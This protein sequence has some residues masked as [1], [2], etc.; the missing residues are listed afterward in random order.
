MT[1][2]TTWTMT[3]AELARAWADHYGY[4]GNRGGWIGYNDERLPH[5]LHKT[6]GE[7]AAEGGPVSNWIPVAHGWANFADVLAGLGYIVE[8]VGIDWSRSG[9]Q[10]RLPA[11]AGRAS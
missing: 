4:R 11:R 1:T 5:N 9:D 8:G 10:P 2:K 7:I 3:L 6:V